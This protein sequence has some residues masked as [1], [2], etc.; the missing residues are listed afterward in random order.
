MAYL[1]LAPQSSRIQKALIKT[2]EKKSFILKHSIG[3]QGIFKN[4][5][6]EYIL[7]LLQQHKLNFNH[8]LSLNPEEY[9][10]WY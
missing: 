2:G 10:S 6:K 5:L 3:Q 7:S 8:G 1:P 4:I 9:S